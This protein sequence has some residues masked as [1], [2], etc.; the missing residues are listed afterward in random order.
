MVLINEWFPN[1]NGTD[2]K[3]EFIE[4]YNND[5]ALV[6]LSGWILKTTAKKSFSLSGY[7]IVANGYLVLKKA[8]T[9]LSLKN[10]GESVF[11][12]D[13]GGHLVDKSSYLG[14]APSGQSYSRI[15]YPT[16]E[17][18]GAQPQSFAWGNPSPGTANKIDLHNG[19]SVN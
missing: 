7:T 19:I 5:K 3:G 9:N 18:D 17:N 8:Q 2:A 16:D 10:A 14:A 11:L 6:N 12:Y 1:P 13:A 4:L 15:Y